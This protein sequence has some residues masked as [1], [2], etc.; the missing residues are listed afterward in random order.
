VQSV[1]ATGVDEPVATCIAGVIRGIVFPRT[2]STLRA[3]G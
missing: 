3:P 1:H 2:G